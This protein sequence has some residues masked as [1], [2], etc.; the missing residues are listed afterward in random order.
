MTDDRDEVFWKMMVGEEIGRGASRVTYAMKNDNDYVL[1]I[2]EE[3]VDW[4]QNLLEWE[5]W[6]NVKHRPQAVKKWFAPC[7]LISKCGRM[8]IQRRVKRLDPNKLPPKL[9]HFLADFNTKNFGLIGQQVVACDYGAVMQ[10]AWTQV[11]YAKPKMKKVTW[12]D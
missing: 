10:D 7:L 3:A 12:Y 5:T 9:P 1:K 4:H 2:C 8:L 6:L 11:A